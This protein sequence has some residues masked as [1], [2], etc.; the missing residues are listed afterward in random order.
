MADQ[1]NEDEKKKYSVVDRRWKE[2]GDEAADDTGAAE[3]AEESATAPGGGSN[4]VEEEDYGP[5][6][7]PRIEDAIRFSLNAI[8]EQVFF[9]LGLLISGSRRSEPDIDRALR[10]TKLFSSL[11]DR[12]AGPLT[13]VG[14]N[15]VERKDPTLE[16]IL[17]FCF[18]VMQG[19]IFV[20]LGLIAN[21]ATGL[22]TKD[23][24]QAK[25]GVDFCAALL[26]QARPLLNPAA[27]KK[28]EGLLADL[29]INYVTHK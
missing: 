9:A 26:E 27:A 29:Q 20:R 6:R 3:A 21:P 4:G 22:I 7:E 17:D 13:D 1:K 11:A 15:E 28:L 19:Q 14:L 5:Q 2:G 10:I 16:D 18:N 12:F 23:P 8:R 24:D 25:L